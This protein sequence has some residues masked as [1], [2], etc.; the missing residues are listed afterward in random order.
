MYSEEAK[1]AEVERCG[2]ID[3]EMS[4]LSNLLAELC[5][6]TTEIEKKFSSVCKTEDV[7]ED[8]DAKVP[9]APLTQ[10]SGNIRSSNMTL[11][12]CIKRLASLS[13]RSE[14]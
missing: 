3:V 4:R 9:I 14:L 2:E 1:C 13:N 6:I 7:R 12:N 8:K 5:S 11:S 10:M